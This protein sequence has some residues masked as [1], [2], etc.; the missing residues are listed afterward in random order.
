MGRVLPRQMACLL[1][2]Q[3]ERDVFPQL[4]PR[5]RLGGDLSRAGARYS[6]RSTSAG[7]SRAAARPGQNA[8]ALAMTIAASVMSRSGRIGVM[9]LGGMPGPGGERAQLHRPADTASRRP[10]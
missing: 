3:A 6:A 7:L 8:T 2:V 9:A 10:A 1:R 4:L 5:S